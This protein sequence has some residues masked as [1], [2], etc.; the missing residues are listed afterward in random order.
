MEHKV[1]VFHRAALKRLEANNA[2]P[3]K[4]AEFQR[5][6]FS[7][8]SRLIEAGHKLFERLEPKQ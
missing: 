1:V 5:E 6:Q 2:P 8:F 4:L 3:E 7:Y